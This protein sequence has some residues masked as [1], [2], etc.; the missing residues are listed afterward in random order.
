MHSDPD[1]IAAALR[2]AGLDDVDATTRRRAEY[3]S[4]ASLYRVPPAV[5]AFPRD[6][7]E[8]EAAVSVSRSSGVPITAR[9]AGTSIAGNAIG[10]G[11]VLDVRRHLDRIVDL[12][13]DTRRAVVEPG[14]VLDD[15]QA[16]AAPHGLRFGPDPSSHDRCTIG[17]MIGNNA[18][19][20]RA[21]GYGRT[22]DNV[23]ALDVV[24]G[25]GQRFVAGDAATSAGDLAAA[26][27]DLVGAHAEV[28]RAEL[29]RFDRQVS[30]YGLHHLL[31]ERGADLARALVGSEGT[32]ALTVGATLT[33]VAVPAVTALVV[34]GYPDMAAAAD[35]VPALLGHDAVAI[36][37]MDARIVEVVRAGNRPV[38]ALPRGAGWLIVELAGAEIAEVIARVPALVADADALDH[39]LVTDPDAARALWRIREDGAGLVTR[40]APAPAHAGWE[41]T[42]VP[43]ARL[44]SYLR[45][46]ERLLAD[47][48]LSGVPYG[49]FGDGCVHVRIDF[50][51]ASADGTAV[52]RR[53]LTEA[54]ELVTAHGGSLSG[55]HGDGRARSELLPIMYGPETIALFG[56]F[57]HLFDPDGLL[58]PGVLVRPAPVDEA[59]RVAAGVRLTAG[60]A[61]DYA[62]DGGDFAAAVH[63]CTGVG[64]CTVTHAGEGRVMC[65]SYLATGDEKDSTRGRARVLQEMVD[66]RLVDGGWSAPEVH[67]ALALCLACKGCASDCPTGVDMATYRAEVLH[68]TYRRR[69]RPRTHYSLGWL[70]RWVRL[71]GSVPRLAN[72]LLRAPVVGRLAKRA[73]GVDPR[74]DLPAFATADRLDRAATPSPSGGGAGEVLLW[75][76]TFTEGFT[77]D[78]AGAAV[79]VLESAGLRVRLAERDRC[80]GLT[81]ISTGQLDTARRMVRRTVDALAAEVAASG[82]ALTIVGLEPSCTAVLRQDA[83]HLLGHDDPAAR[84]GAAATRTLAEVLATRRPDWTPPRL[85][86][87]TLV[88]QPHCHQHAV[89]G[90]QADRAL[91]AACGATVEVVGGCC[92][93]AGDFGMQAGRYDTSVRI[94][95]TALLPALRAAGEDALVLAD[96]FSCRT[97]VEHLAGRRS[98]HLAQLLADAARWPS[99]TG[100]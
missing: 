91:L 41:D 1:E 35:A 47:H 63:R 5:V 23:V 89:M 85:D 8:I 56:A 95:E 80:C 94:A 17:G 59:V 48:G 19:G 42:A 51:F 27:R 49:H 76:D 37:G 86:G 50:P 72:A 28:V 58:N 29:G 68:Q 44:G 18:C 62:A 6:A 14:V 77:P 36:E 66:G 67:D 34:L 93:L 74:R 55:E 26:A 98:V 83:L 70:P 30:G 40:V 38:P 32:C 7:D 92:G 96:G 82:G 99:G 46:F 79:E 20:S 21:L 3:S 88:A 16:A 71:A 52:F 73:A 24:A 12:D 11:I 33:L 61:L 84:T 53:F 13:P 75:I 15:L 9:G 43:P 87:V 57:K 97:Q 65:P 64:K 45:A 22:V 39:L 78:V 25:T 4:D 54:A 100:G 60:L 2:A 90:W 69:L 31:P 10:P 81:W